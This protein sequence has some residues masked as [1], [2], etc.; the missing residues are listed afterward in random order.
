MDDQTGPF[1][2]APVVEYLLVKVRERAVSDVVQERRDDRDQTR[3][4]RFARAQ[5]DLSGRLQ[6]VEDPLGH[7][8]RA[9]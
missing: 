9:D 1:F 7:E 8:G 4:L 6:G 2:V 5:G 3:A